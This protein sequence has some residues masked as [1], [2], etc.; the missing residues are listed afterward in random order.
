MLALICCTLILTI[1]GGLANIE[2]TT[3]QEINQPQEVYE[4][5]YHDT[6]SLLFFETTLE[7]LESRAV[8]IVRGRIGD[9]AATI[10]DYSYEFD[11]PWFVMGYTGV[12]FEIYEVIK[13]DLVVGDTIRILEP[14]YVRN[15]IQFIRHNY[16]PSIPHQEYIFFLGHQ[17]DPEWLADDQQALAHMFSVAHGSNG[18]FLV[19]EHRNF[20]PH[21]F[22]A[23][24]LSLG[25]GQG[26]FNI[27]L[28]MR[29]WREVIAAYMD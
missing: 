29:L 24:D 25:T 8:H 22:N 18:R 5:V 4:V 20:T 1:L 26:M 16:M 6:M 7:G 23:T 10:L 12:S 14:H 11:P 2:N 21:N 13:G 27:D 9:D 3:S 28:H 19:P 17:I 15:G